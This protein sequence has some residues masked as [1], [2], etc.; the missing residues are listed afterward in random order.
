MPFSKVRYTGIVR[1]ST[2]SANNFNTKFPN[3]NNFYIEFFADKMPYMY[4][5]DRGHFMVD[6]TTYRCFIDFDD[7]YAYEC[8][9]NE[10]PNGNSFRCEDGSPR[11]DESQIPD[12]EVLSGAD[13]ILYSPFVSGARFVIED[14]ATSGQIFSFECEDECD[15]NSL[16]YLPQFEPYSDPSI[17]INSGLFRSPVI[18]SVD[19]QS[20]HV[21]SF[22]GKSSFNVSSSNTHVVL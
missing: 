19:G 21:F 17:Y 8:L 11:I 14:L 1:N 3:R 5:A 7:Y 22:Q 16:T 18:S 4:P 15:I 20:C 10:V 9:P 6:G 12:G 2:L 13:G